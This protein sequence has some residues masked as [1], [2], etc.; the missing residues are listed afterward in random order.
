MTTNAATPLVGEAT[1]QRLR[2]PNGMTAVRYFLALSLIATHFCVL[3]GL[4]L[5][6]WVDGD[7]VVKSFFVISGFFVLYSY[8]RTGDVKQYARRRFL[9]TYPLYFV[10]VAGSTALGCL[11]STLPAGQYFTHPQTWRYLLCNALFLNFAEPSLPGVFTANVMPEVNGSLWFMKVLVGFYIL[12][13]FI[14]W[15][16]RR[17]GRV[18]V[19]AV[20]FLL[21][22]G[23]TEWCRHLYATTGQRIFDLLHHQTPGYLPYFLAGMAALLFFDRLRRHLGWW[24]VVAVGIELTAR[25]ADFPLIIHLKPVTYAVVLFTAGW[26]VRPLRVLHRVPDITYGMYLI[27][28]PVIQALLQECRG[29]TPWLLLASATAITALLAY[30]GWLL[31]KTK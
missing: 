26:F 7:M 11:F 18:S 25:L 17:Y 27:H 28:V 13:P 9:R 4:P 5:A 8:L 21:S 23:Y 12:L 29:T 19:L 15:L 22:V 6:W 20:L 30:Y 10:V 3:A 16:L 1:L 14:V 24:W 2:Q 31:T